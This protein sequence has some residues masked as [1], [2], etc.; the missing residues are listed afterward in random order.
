MDRFRRDID[1]LFD[2]FMYGGSP[3][4]QSSAGVRAPAIESWVD[5]EN[6]IVRADLPGV[7]PKDVEIT[8]TGNTLTLRGT[9]QS[10]REET[11]RDYLFREVSYGS[12][13]RSLT[14]PEGVK[15]EEI[16]ATY[17]NGVLELTIP[18]PRQLAARKIPIQLE[19]KR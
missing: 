4:L 7:D 12:F 9:R 3:A 11:E 15:S 16:K 18:V 5:G 2:R 19:N 8:A 13:E 14:L 1:E 10:K 6:L 17:Q